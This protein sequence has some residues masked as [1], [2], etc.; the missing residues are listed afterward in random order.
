[1]RAAVV[2]AIRIED[3]ARPG[4]ALV[5]RVQVGVVATTGTSSAKNDFVHLHPHLHEYLQP[6]HIRHKNLNGIGCHGNNVPQLIVEEY[7]RPSE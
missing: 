5:D 4:S 6:S 3:D 7:F 2:E 1:M